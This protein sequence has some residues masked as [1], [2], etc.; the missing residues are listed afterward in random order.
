MWYKAVWGAQW[1]SNSLV[2]VCYLFT[3]IIVLPWIESMVSNVTFPLVTWEFRPTN[4]FSFTFILRREKTWSFLTF[5]C[6]TKNGHGI[7]FVRWTKR[8]GC[9]QLRQGTLFHHA[10]KSRR[11]VRY[12]YH[13][14][15]FSSRRREKT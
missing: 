3:K 15:S 8:R 14:F 2:K 5:T 1:N 4:Y 13:S 6:W 10:V 12:L 7:Y 11:P 9:F